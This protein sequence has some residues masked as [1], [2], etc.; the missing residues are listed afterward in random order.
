VPKYINSSAADGY[1]KGA[2]LYGLNRAV[3]VIRKED[4]VF[5]TEGYKDAIA[6]HAAGFVNTVALCGTAL[7]DSHIAL[8]KKYTNRA[9]L[10]LDGDEAGQAASKKAVLRL[11]E[12]G[13]DA[14][15][16]L[17]PGGGD[18]DSLFR[19]LG[20]EEFARMIGRLQN[21]PH[22]SECA[23]LTVC[24][25]YPE[26]TFRLRGGVLV[27]RPGGFGPGDG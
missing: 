5:I 26:V 1:D 10:L 16:A 17:I 20:R 6:M 2:T 4:Y 19:R 3:A 14:D 21:R 24:L 27:Y 9:C 18:P 23:L 15:S 8:L 25:L 22:S 13:M 12:A 7:T 11:R